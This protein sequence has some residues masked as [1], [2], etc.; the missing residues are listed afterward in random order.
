MINGDGSNDGSLHERVFTQALAR[1][2][3]L[4][5]RY[6]TYMRSQIWLISRERQDTP[7]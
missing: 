2:A 6:E 7:L 4:D 5:R 1:A 3:L